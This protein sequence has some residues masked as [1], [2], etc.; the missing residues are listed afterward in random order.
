MRS[1]LLMPERFIT[2]LE[3]TMAKRDSYLLRI[4]PEV[5]EALRGWADDEFRSLNGQIEFVLHRALEQAGRLPK[6]QSKSTQHA[7]TPVAGPTD[8]AVLAPQPPHAAD[9]S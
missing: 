8:S 9:E 3:A 4:K 6:P 2:K 1:Q 5:L 7:E